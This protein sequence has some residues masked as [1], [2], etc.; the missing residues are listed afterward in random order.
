MHEAHTGGASARTA[1]TTGFRRSAPVVVAAAAIMF[2]VFAGFIPS[3][4]P[5]IK[6]LALALSVGILADA[7]VVRMLLV[8]AA[9]SLLGDRAW[10]LPHWLRW[11]PEIDVEGDALASAR[12]TAGCGRCSAGTRG[13]PPRRS[14]R[15]EER[16][17]A[18]RK[19]PAPRARAHVMTFVNTYAM[20]T[21]VRWQPSPRSTAHLG[22]RRVDGRDES[23]M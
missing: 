4:D 15:P 9:M 20:T 22:G 17:V 16:S 19:L 13:Q 14:L 6:V 3:H 10:A 7:F 5:T 12:R 18:W 21:Q 2:A 23:W 11:L 8:P 1:I